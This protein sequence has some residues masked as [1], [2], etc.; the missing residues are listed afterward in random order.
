VPTACALAEAHL[1]HAPGV[2]DARLSALFSQYQAAGIPDEGVDA[3]LAD[4]RNDWRRRP[5]AVSASAVV[6]KISQP[7]CRQF[8]RAINR[9]V[10]GP[11]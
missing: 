7:N 3:A 10:K 9:T 5:L 11:Q 2:L 8:R 4:V 1:V 6:L